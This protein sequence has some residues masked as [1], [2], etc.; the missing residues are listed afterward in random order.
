[1]NV[2]GLLFLHKTGLST[3]T[4]EAFSTYLKHCVCVELILLYKTG[5][6]T[7]TQEVLSMALGAK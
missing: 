6:S 4:Q 3:I 2:F 7:T 1:M 5:T